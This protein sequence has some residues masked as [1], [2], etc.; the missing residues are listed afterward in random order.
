MSKSRKNTRP[1]PHT[2]SLDEHDQPD[3]PP[4]PNTPEELHKLLREK[5]E[6]S[7]ARSPIHPGHTAPFDYLVHAF[8]E[9]RFGIHA[10]SPSDCVVW[11]NRGGGKTMLG[12]VATLLD[13]IYKPGI[14]VRILGGA[15][16]QSQHMHRHLMRLFETASLTGLFDGSPTATRITLKNGSRVEMLAQSE[17]SVRGTRVQKIRCDEVELFDRAIWEAAQLTT[18]A[19][20]LSGPWGS[21]VNGSVEALSTMNEPMGLMWEVINHCGS[22]AQS[23]TLFRWGVIDALENCPPERKCESCALFPDCQGRAKRDDPASGGHFRIQDALVQIGRVSRPR[24]ESEMLCLRPNREDTVFPEFNP[25]LHVYDDGTEPGNADGRAIFCGMDFGFRN[26]TVILWATRSDDGVL[27]I[28]DE[29][30]ANGRTIAQHAA[31]IKQSPWPR[32]VFLGVDIAGR[33][34]AL[35]DGKAAID[36]LRKSGFV[37]RSCKTPVNTGLEKI[38]TR[39]RSATDQVTLLIHKRCV[40]LIESMTRY[41]YDSRDKSAVEPMKNGPDHAVDALRYLLV[42]LE[43]CFQTKALRY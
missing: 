1:K 35:T 34:H 28:L 5:F 15:L 36:E 19:L 31:T 39:L 29:R 32:P 18:R 21:T 30:V 23:R 11:A 42:N 37:V 10:G 41:R 17:T 40:K 14:E 9:G 6:L 22:E 16:Y 2:D 12:A 25:D 7:I 8:F 27:R 43:N 13:L 24:W 38:H 3:V 4:C 33:Q 26:D 20:E